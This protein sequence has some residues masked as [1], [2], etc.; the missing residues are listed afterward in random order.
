MGL[1]LEELMLRAEGKTLEFKRD[2]SSLDRILRTLVAFANTS[3]GILLVG[4]EDKTRAVR[5]VDDPLAAE[6]KLANVVSDGISPTLLPGFEYLSWRGTQV[7]A[8]EVAPGPA[9]PYF[10]RRDGVSKG[11]YVRVGSSNRVADPALVAELRR[12]ATRRTFD[13]EPLRDETM[14]SL[15]L[16]GVAESFPDRGRI[17]A[18]EM[19]TFGVATR[20][21]R[22]LVPTTGGVLLFGKGRARRFPDAWLQCGRFQ[23]EDRTTILDSVD[24]HDHLPQ[25]PERALEF[26]RKHAVRALE[27]RKIRHEERWSVPIPALREALV[28]AVVHA[29]Y[30]LRG[31]PVRLSCFDERIEIENPGLLP[32]GLATEN[33][34]Q[35]VSVI[36][37]HVIARVF[38]ELGL[39]EQW[40]SGIRRMIETCR[41]A[42]L[43]PP[44]FEEI[45]FRFRV[46]FDLSPVGMQIRDARDTTILALLESHPDGLSS[47]VIAREIGLTQRALQSRLNRLVD[48]GDVAAIGSSPRDPRRRY[49]LARRMTETGRT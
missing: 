47:G 39:I 22:R 25:L 2:L 24:H 28:N 35:G 32:F 31:G 49:F 27:I 36:R 29:D 15:D 34:T 12:V 5:G 6:E 16:A 1:R 43:R 8:V 30:A 45:G 26:V 23:G 11:I 38:R 44:N 3:G 14:E 41:K 13:E 20:D 48:S 40:G 4:V 9:R 18:E 7:L 19:R 10:V 37:N 21:G 17:R 46:T 42:G 33:L